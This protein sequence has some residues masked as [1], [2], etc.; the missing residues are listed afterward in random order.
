MGK[1]IDARKY[2]EGLEELARNMKLPL[3]EDD[4]E[5]RKALILRFM[6][7]ILEL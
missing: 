2:P 4:I 7:S 3:P 6:E 5:G 1:I